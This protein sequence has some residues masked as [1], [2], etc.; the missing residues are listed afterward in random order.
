MNRVAFLLTNA[1]GIMTSVPLPLSGNTEAIISFF[2]HA[3]NSIL[4]QRG[5]YPA[6][7]FSQVPKYGL[8]L[9]VTSDPELKEYITRILSQLKG[10]GRHVT[11][12]FPSPRLRF[13]LWSLPPL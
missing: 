10:K 13:P 4:Y 7:N 9:F 11:V 6:E 2:G 12:I 5:I 1:I 3:V 8:S